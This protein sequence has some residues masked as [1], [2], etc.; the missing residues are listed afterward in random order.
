MPKVALLYPDAR[1]LYHIAYK[2]RRKGD[3]FVPPERGPIVGMRGQYNYWAR[4]TG[5]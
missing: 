2:Q 3:S 4:I 1:V 5:S